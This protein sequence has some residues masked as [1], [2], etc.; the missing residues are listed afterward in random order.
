[1]TELWS[2][3]V[4]VI[5]FVVAAIGTVAGG[6]RLASTGDVLADRSGL[7]EA[8]FGA[9]LFGGVISASGIVMSATA[10]AADQPALAYSN[11]LGG[12]AAQTAALGIADIVYRR[13][14]L[15]HAAASLPNAI[16]AV[17]LSVLLLLALLLAYSPEI[18]VGGIHPGS[19]LLSIT[20]VAGFRVVQEAKRNPMWTPKQTS[21]TVADEPDPVGSK[22]TSRSLWLEFVALGILVSA[23][24]WVVAHAAQTLVQE[25]GIEQSV[26]GAVFMGVVN[27]IPEAVTAVAAVRRGALTMAMAAVLGG[28]AFDVLNLVVADVAYRPGSIYHQT[29]S[30]DVMMCAAAALMTVMILGGLLRRELRGPGRIGTESVL[31][32]LI[33]AATIGLVALPDQ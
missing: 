4:S 27:A 33:Y 8:V 29:G 23:A 11:A 17:L 24:G 13:A 3:H 31:M 16:S 10:A 2:L 6:I 9:L 32:L 5:A 26:V 1:M 19:V 12:I 22:R 25:G 20:Y 30:D 7:G 14:N 28:N 18:T 21:S 15:E